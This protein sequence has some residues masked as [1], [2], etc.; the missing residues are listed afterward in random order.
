MRTSPRFLPGLLAAAVLV[1]LTA[2]GS[3]ARAQSGGVYDL[4]WHKVAGGGITQSSGGAFT[5]GGT[6]GQADAHTSVGGAYQ[7]RGGFWAG[8]AMRQLVDAPDGPVAPRP[9]FALRGFAHNPVTR[10]GMNVSFSLGSAEPA[11]L[12]LLDIG[13][14][15]VRGVSVGA[16]GPGAHVVNLSR[17]GA[18]EPGVYWLR[19]RQGSEQ[20]TVK[21]VVLE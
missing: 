9:R 4:G 2:L 21:A 16:L 3:A 8:V 6:F 17:G 14:R 10:S 7:L 18:I 11:E 13:G 20:K 19:L 5:L 15:R 1:T 12:D